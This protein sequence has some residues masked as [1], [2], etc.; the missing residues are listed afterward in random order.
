MA[1]I[2]SYT[3]NVYIADRSVSARGESHESEASQALMFCFDNVS[4]ENSCLVVPECHQK[5]VKSFSFQRSSEGK[6]DDGKKF[7]IAKGIVKVCSLYFKPEDLRKSVVVI[8]AMLSLV[9]TKEAVKVHSLGYYTVV[10][11]LC[12]SARVDADMNSSVFF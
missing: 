6:A 2:S 7:M 12:D 3:P 10:F 5:G 1:K 11:V 9:T 8:G 4:P